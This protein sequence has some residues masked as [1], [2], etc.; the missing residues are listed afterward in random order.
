MTSPAIVYTFSPLMAICAGRK[1]AQKR[2]TAIKENI[3]FMI[4]FL[5]DGL[6]FFIAPLIV[7]VFVLF[8]ALGGIDLIPAYCKGLIGRNSPVESLDPF[9]PGLFNMG[10]H[11]ERIA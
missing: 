6:L 7:I 5:I 1:K 8:I 11:A 4:C 2:R 9:Y 3:F 10:I